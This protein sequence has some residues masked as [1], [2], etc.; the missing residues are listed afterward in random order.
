M[1]A[2]HTEIAAVQFGLQ[3][4]D[5][6]QV[7][8]RAEV[9]T[10]DLFDGQRP[11][12]SGLYDSHLGTT[13]ARYRCATCGRGPRQ[14]PGHPGLLELP[15]PLAQPVGLQEIPRWLKVVC[16]QCGALMFDPLGETTNTRVSRASAARRLRAASGVKTEGALCPA[17]GAPHPK[18]VK[19][20]AD[21]FTYQAEWPGR[22]GAPPTVRVLLP[23]QLDRIFSRVSDEAVDALGRD[24]ATQHPR[25]LLV[26]QLQVPPV[27]V[28]PAVRAAGG[29]GSPQH[30]MVSNVLDLQQLVYDLLLGSAGAAP[31]GGQKR[32]I[33][34]SGRPVEALG[35]RLA[36]KQGRIRRSLLGGRSWSIGRNTIS[37]NSQLA[38]DQVGIPESFARSLPVAETVQPGN[39]AYLT[40][41]FLNGRR[42]YPGASRVWRA[43]TGTTHDVDG[44]RGGA[45]LEVGDVLF[46]DT[47]T[48]DWAL[49]NRQPSLERSSIN[50]HRVVVSRAPR[51]DLELPAPP[52]QKT[53]QINVGGTPWYNADFDGD[54]MNIIVLAQPGPRA[55]ARHLASLA[56]AFIST[57][58]SGPVAG[59]VQDS[60]VGCFLL[61]RAPALGKLAAMRLFESGG[62]RPAF[63]DLAPGEAITGR[64]AVSRL[65]APTPVSLARRP[66]WFSATA[67]PYVAFRPDET[68]TVLD[69]GA[70]T[71]GVLDKATVGGGASGGVFH[72]V[73]R[74]FGPAAALDAI[75][76]FQQAA[77]AHLNQR[78]FSVSISDMRLP[79]AR[80]AEVRGVVAGMVAESGALAARLVAG[81]VVP[82]LGLTV[83]EFY[84]QNQREALKVPDL[85]LGPVLAAAD[86]DTN[87]LVQMV[88]T[89]SKGNF[90]NVLN[91]SGVVGPITLNGRRI[92]APPAGRALPYFPLG[93]L[94]PAA[95]GFV[96]N[97]YVD[98]LTAVEHYFASMNGRHDLTNKALTTASTGFANR[99]SIMATQSAATDVLRA[100]VAGA[101]L[102]QP[103]YGDDGMDA[104]Q[105]EPVAFPTAALSDAEVAARYGP[106]A[107]GEVA[108]LLADRDEFRAVFL[109][110]EAV[111]FGVAFSDRVLGPVDVR[112][113]AEEVLGGRPGAPA[114]DEAA[115]AAMHREVGAFCAGAPFLLLNRRQAAAG[116]QAPP[117]L[118]AAVA[119]LCRLLRAEL[120][121]A[122]LRALRATPALLQAV[123]AHVARRFARSLVS[124]GEAVGV[125]ASQ[126]V[127]E[128][129]T[130]Y[131]LDSH[132]R[133]VE[134]GT[135]KAAVIARPREIAG[136]R[137]LED[138]VFPE[139][140]FRGLGR[141]GRPTN[142]RALLQ[143]LADAVKLLTLAQLTQGKRPA[144]L[145]ERF[146]SPA[147]LAAGAPDDPAAFAPYTGDWA[148]MREYL[149]HGG[150]APP[151]DLTPWC[152]RFL[153]DRRRLVSK[154]ITLEAV[155]ARVRA[156]T[157][158]AFVVRSPEGGSA[159]APEVVLRVYLTAGAL[160]R[161]G[162]KAGGERTAGGEAG[163]RQR[164]ALA[165]FELIT[166][167]P[168]R[169]IP[170]VRD[171][172]VVQTLRHRVVG[173]GES[174]GDRD[175]GKLV[176][177]EGCLFVRTVG[178]NLH[179]ALLH[180][181]VDNRTLISSSIDDTFRV[182]GAVAARDK[183]ANEYRRSL[184]SKAPNLRHLQLYSRLMTFTGRHSSFELA[185]VTEREPENVL[186]R[187]ATHGPIDVFTRA[188]L[189]GVTNPVRGMAAPMMMGG[190][191]RLGAAT[192]R[193]TVD[194]EFVAAQRSS[195][196][197]VVLGL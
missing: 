165:A 164:A 148:W 57:K 147:E 160:R 51:G 97:N 105:V 183:I 25:R 24:P 34:I 178:S 7:V 38:L 184:G 134:G 35:R 98:G 68:L 10:S 189:E 145:Y 167:R 129:Y 62:V 33:A 78:G 169:G 196:E 121:T 131:F 60:T 113:V 168:L 41:F 143:E 152:A 175:L 132:H 156:A 32:G 162:G 159:A 52:A 18:I 80:A 194:C 50:A 161:A 27:S 166:R 39:L 9:R 2:P 179:G 90:K 181:H 46:R 163:G 133:S 104:R 112:A 49:L 59:Q 128:T 20:P 76:N 66:S 117:H 142:D 88:A 102:V 87:G 180:R 30:D 126:A 107:P 137:K 85:A 14:C 19:S 136:A 1:A 47:V 74:A 94:S 65:L 124:V 125:L 86:F 23:Y 151:P 6:R 95:S 77:I 69:R 158:G 16:L 111:S 79:P 154:S 13:D 75:F 110:V 173:P 122:R 123:F 109:V 172:R 170:G 26:R 141:D 191:P 73:A 71:S 64:E 54:E 185:G 3:S 197:N 146:P 106:G 190:V 15:F 116:R 93:D 177:E 55:E 22:E 61:S 155:A 182:F 99:K 138:E 42:Q 150:A 29:H 118:E 171:A 5:D 8:S 101:A 157:P 36:R 43:A 139:M 119:H 40:R 187:A 135:N 192:T 45:R 89:G 58:T 153:L 44:L 193:L 84:E 82:P 37:G 11:V 140:L 12:P 70:L 63:D 176:R 72:R 67:E 91:I 28:R 174:P 53:F 103:L 56:A 92:E 144:V 4:D 127:E 48:G 120:A 81:Q 188:A 21:R 114:P 17:C 195:I 108:R 149:A 100:V 186:L 31:R 130:Q 83:K 96:S 115:L